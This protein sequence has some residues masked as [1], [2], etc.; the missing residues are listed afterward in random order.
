MA[1]VGAARRLVAR[2]HGELGEPDINAVHADLA[3]REVAER[4]AACHVWAVGEYLAGHAGALAG[5]GE[6]RGAVGVGRVL[7]G[8]I[9]LK[10]GSAI[11]ARTVCRVGTGGVVGVH[12]M[13][14]VGRNHEKMEKNV[15]IVRVAALIRGLNKTVIT[16][17]DGIDL[18]DIDLWLDIILPTF[19][20]QPVRIE[21]PQLPN[22][23]E[24]P[25]VWVNLD[26]KLPN[27]P[28]LPEPPELPELPSFIPEI[29]IEL[30]V[31]PPAPELPKLPSA[32]ESIINIAKVIWKIYCIVK[33]KF[34]LVW[35]SSVKAKIEQLTQ[36]TYEVKWIDRIMDF[37]NL[38]VAPVHNYWLDY[39]ISSHVDFQFEFS[40]FYDYLN[41]LTKQINNLTTY[42][43]NWIS[44]KANN[45]I[46]DNIVTW[47]WD[48]IDNA[49]LEFGVEWNLSMS[50]LSNMN[51]GWLES[52]DI[53]YVDYD[54]AKARLKEVLAYF[55]QETKNTTMWDRVKSSIS[56][57][58]NQID[59]V[60]NVKSNIEGLEKVKN[61]A[62]DYLDIEKWNYDNLA[63]LI[64][65]DYDSFLAMVDSNE[66][67]KK[68]ALK[69][70][71]ILA[72]NVNLFNLDSSTK[73]VVKNITKSNPY[74]MILSNKKTI[75]DWYWDAINSNT[76][77][78][79]WLS[80]S[81]YLVLR[82]NISSMK[83][84]ITTLYSV[85]KPTSLTS[86]I[87]KN[88]VK[89]SDKT[90]L[91]AAWWWERLW[92]NMEVA[93]VVDPSVLSEWIYG[94]I[95]EWADKWK[96]TKIVYSDSFASN[97]WNQYYHTDHTN[98][99]DIVL[100]D[101]GSVYL[102]CW[103]WICDN[104]WWWFNKYY[105]SEVIN[106]IPLK[107]SRINFDWDTKL[108]ISD[109]NLE[110]KNWQVDGQTYDDLRFSW[111]AEDVD[112]YLIK[113]VERVDNSYEKLD[114]T[115]VAT[116]VLY[117]LAIPDQMDIDELYSWNA[118]LEILKGTEKVKK[119]FWK[120]LV[121][122]VSYDDGQ[123]VVDVAITDID[124]KWYYARVAALNL[125]GDTFYVTSPWSNQV[126]AWKQIV[127]DDLS[128]EWSAVL[129]RPSVNEVVSEWDYLD[130]FVWTKY[131]LT[132]NWED[133]VAL[134]YISLLKDGKV[135]DEKYTSNVNDLV[136]TDIG[137]HTKMGNER[138]STIWI[139][140]FGNKTEKTIIIDYSIP[141]VSITDVSKNS[142]WKTVSITAK[143]SQDIDQWNI[144]FQRKRWEQ[145]KTMARRGIDEVDFSVWPKQD[146]IVWSPYSYGNE[147]AMYD[148][149]WNVIAL[150]NPVT[151]EITLQPEYKE[152]YE[153]RA[154]IQDGILLQISDK[155]TKQSIFSI[156]I[157]AQNCLKFAA[158]NYSIVDLPESWRMGMFNGWKAIYKDWYNVMYAS[159]T[160]HLYSDLSL[161]WMY[162]YDRELDAV[163]LTLY[164]PSDLSK[165]N[166]IKVWVKVKPL[167]GD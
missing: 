45:V 121:Q 76:A 26:L 93:N 72:Y 142:D 166:P 59:K 124:R 112:A 161:E 60:N 65:N 21:L 12:G 55:L 89:I 20:F 79:L 66:I 154:I 156:N 36:R 96:L 133:N 160:C 126:V 80:Q 141:E 78:D 162:D 11:Y 18:T 134:S 107:E 67:N 147:I 130:W 88:S 103:K 86:L 51:L 32:I 1:R 149:N 16:I 77:S 62:I 43:T 42:W 34:G 6:H 163:A 13:G 63:E 30:P 41:T 3:V 84:Q 17:Q 151:A 148:K 38:S 22:L 19:N 28:M 164:V 92:S 137:I 14:V 46:N 119:L 116:P 81:Q 140:Q 111:D 83:D 128:P 35:E 29:E 53:E 68:S 94:K 155:K 73:D 159:P 144:S 91:S 71:Q 110:I 49:S 90:L 97:I 105:V 122:V 31:L 54:S 165:S 120:D 2:V 109:W 139:D 138:F 167:M 118:K 82:D 15:N 23:P 5:G 27:I 47:I 113:L 52:D 152:N 95:I 135:L 37:T 132:V 115:S 7:L 24:P 87:A 143:L 74:D 150:M 33:S 75:I 9:E 69:S 131:K 50:D 40:T 57:I 158:D 48:R 117:V 39:E 108:K 125:D 8:A 101:D 102:K 104:G 70:G 4:G 153:I 114:Y 25:S 129:F 157:P 146:L 127:W 58:E 99:D 123:S 64:N 136:S 44:D 10:H 100:R 56:S 98:V 106:E 145:W 85:T 61:E